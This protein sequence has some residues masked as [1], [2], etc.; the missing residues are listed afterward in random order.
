MVGCLPNRI[1]FHGSFLKA[2]PLLFIETNTPGKSLA[3][4]SRW[5]KEWLY[6][7]FTGRHEV[8]QQ[9]VCRWPQGPLDMA[10]SGRV[11]L[12]VGGSRLFPSWGWW[13]SR[14]QARVD[15]DPSNMLGCGL[16]TAL[17]SWATLSRSAFL[18]LFSDSSP[19]KDVSVLALV[20]RI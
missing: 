18:P 16:A 1:T 15:I 2:C 5:D 8:T 3:I 7:P 9:P 13:G 20:N 19:V 11:R 17:V 14:S 10:S 6:P 4:Q 12:L